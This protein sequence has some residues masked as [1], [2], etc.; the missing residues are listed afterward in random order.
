[1]GGDLQAI[2]TEGDKRSYYTPLNRFCQESGLKHITPK[3]I[4]TYIPAKTSIDY[5]LLKKSTTTIHYT[6]INTKI[7]NHTPEYGE[8]KA[9]ILDLLQLGIINTPDAKHTHKNPTTRS[10]PPVQLPIPRNFIDLYQLGNPSTSVNTNH[11]SQTLPTLLM[12]H[13]ATTDQIDYAAAQVMTIIY[14]Y[15]DTA[16]HSHLAYAN[17]NTRHANSYTTQIS[18]I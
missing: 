9:L 16:S 3:D 8:H 5:W 4:Y 2:P 18:D 17:P 13:T 7:T 11:I 1:M 10:H 15:H 14:E 6:N 12:A